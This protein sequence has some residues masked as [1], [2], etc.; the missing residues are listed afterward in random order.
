[1]GAHRVWHQRKASSRIVSIRTSGRRSRF[2]GLDF[3][4]LQSVSL[5]W[6]S[7]Y[8]SASTVIVLLNVVLL[9]RVF[10]EIP[11]PE[12]SLLLFICNV[13]QIILMFAAWYQLLGCYSQSDALLKSILAFATIGYAEDMP[14]V[15]ML[16]IATDF[17]LLAIFLSHPSRSVWSRAGGKG[18]RAA[19]LRKGRFSSAF[20]VPVSRPARLVRGGTGP[21]HN[22]LFYVFY[23]FLTCR[24]A[25]P[26]TLL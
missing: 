21:S 24:G 23:M 5:A 18:N 10:G 13:A 25:A 12:R 26:K 22:I 2:I 14:K 11:K 9:H 6:W 7:T 8:F 16:Q 4:R 3:L 20:E 19:K 17:V 1:M 15:A